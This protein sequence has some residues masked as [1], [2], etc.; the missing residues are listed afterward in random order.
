MPTESDVLKAL[1]GVK[2]PELGKDVVTLH[3]IE[4]VKVHG[5]KVAFTLNLSTPA[6]P[7]WSRL[8]ESA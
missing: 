2:D 4:G 7:L 3:M 6:C 1:A 5:S 8:E